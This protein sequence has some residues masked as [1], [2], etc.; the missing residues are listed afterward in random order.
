MT[1]L[2]AW[3]HRHRWQNLTVTLAQGAVLPGDV[4]VIL[5]RCNRCGT[6]RTETLNGHWPISLLTPPA[7]TRGGA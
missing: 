4:T 3:L 5:S 7:T 2:L 1:R 6:H